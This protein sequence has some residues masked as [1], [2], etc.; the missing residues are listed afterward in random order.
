M[1]S[2][3]EDGEIPLLDADRLDDHH[4]RTARDAHPETEDKSYGSA[5]DTRAIL[6]LISHLRKTPGGK[7]LSAEKVEDRAIA[8]Y[9]KF[10]QMILEDSASASQKKKISELLG[11]DSDVVKARLLL[12]EEDGDNSEG[13]ASGLLGALFP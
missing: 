12:E 1:K 4:K 13:G 2:M 7:D 6:S 5:A 10:C 3:N 11:E 8:L 9:G